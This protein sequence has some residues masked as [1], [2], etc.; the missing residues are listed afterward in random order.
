V[1]ATDPLALDRTGPCR[2]SSRASRPLRRTL[3]WASLIVVLVYLLGVTDQ[4]WPTPDSALYLGLGRSLAAGDGYRFNG[5]PHN[6][7][8]PGLP[9]LLAGIERLVG[10]RF[11]AFNLAM[12]VVGLGAAVVIYRVLTGAAR[13]D[14]AALLAL[15]TAAS[16]S[17]YAEA[18]RILTDMPFVL[19][20]WTTVWACLRACGGRWVW[21]VAVGVL[22]VLGLVVRI[23]GLVAFA[24]LAVALMLQWRSKP[25]RPRAFWAG[26][27]I[28]TSLMASTLV[29]LAMAYRLSPRTPPYARVLVRLGDASP[30]AWL[31]AF[32]GE[33]RDLAPETAALLM[34]QSFGLAGVLLLL[35]AVV[36]SIVLW[37]RAQRLW[38]ALWILY[39]LM[40]AA[41][42]TG[43][44]RA[45]YLL[46]VLPAMLYA[47]LTGLEAVA[48]RWRWGHRR[49][50]PTTVGR[51]G[52]VLVA[53]LALINAP[54]ILR[55]AVWQSYLAW[56]GGYYQ[57]VLHGRYDGLQGMAQAVQAATPADGLVIVSDDERIVHYWSRRRAAT[58][59][60]PVP[61]KTPGQLPPGTRRVPAAGASVV[62]RLPQDSQVA[63]VWREA[64][65]RPGS[66]ITQVF[67]GTRYEVYRVHQPPRPRPA[68][69]TQPG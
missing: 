32:V 63:S 36:G 52:L 56:T 25:G 42:G 13:P 33:L 16:Y 5:Q 69:A 50:T 27:T 54:K 41:C 20:F 66:G 35:L 55:H 45:R 1:T 39:P 49:A 8:A 11:W 53:L 34:G 31:Q 61:L 29:L 58:V 60:G 19:L 6:H 43:S 51:A 46:P 15:A 59:Q 67:Q 40:L 38:A 68:P 44:V 14:L 47:M 3:L 57:S 4:W 30:L 12:C 21:L 18:H 62:L 28:V 48:A 2:D 26:V 24:A 7:V 65:A 23:P 9:L 64:A 37:T 22:S 17:F 10:P